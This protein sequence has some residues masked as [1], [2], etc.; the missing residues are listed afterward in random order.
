MLEDKIIINEIIPYLSI[1]KVGADLEIPLLSIVKCIF[2][3]LKTGC[4]WRELPLKQ[5]VERVG[6]TWNAIYYHFNKWS[7]D[8]SWQKAYQNIIEKYRCYLDLSCVSLDGSQTKAFRGGESVGYNGRKKYNATNILFLVDNQGV[9]LFCSQPISGNHNDLFE[10]KSHFETIRKMANDSKVELE[11][12]FLNADAGFDSQEFRDYLEG[13]F[14]NANIAFNKRNGQVTERDD[15]FDDVLYKKRSMC[16]H[17]F[18]WMDAYKALLI[19]YEK[20]NTTWLSM[21]IM[22]MMHI[23]LRKF[24]NHIIKNHQF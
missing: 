17:P 10:I 15:Y 4:Q 5:F 22:G 18:A 1:G 6:T 11:Y 3:K 23:A 2:Y 13:H 7:K 9:I 8:K 19:R 16:E 24:S 12:I 20:L 21:N 14:I